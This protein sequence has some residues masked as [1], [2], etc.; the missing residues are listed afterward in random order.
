MTVFQYTAR[1]KETGRQITGT[2]DAEDRINAIK[3]LERMRLLPISVRCT[4]VTVSVKRSHLLYYVVSVV[5][6]FA[7]T[8]FCWFTMGKRPSS[9]N[10]DEKPEGPVA[11]S[12]PVSRASKV[13]SETSPVEKVPE[14]I[15]SSVASQVVQDDQ[16]Y[17]P[18]S[19]SSTEAHNERKLKGEVFVVTG[20]QSNIKLA[21]VNILAIPTVSLASHLEAQREEVNIQLA[22]VKF[23]LEPIDWAIES[24][25]D[26]G[27]KFQEKAQNSIRQIRQGRL[28]SENEMVSMKKESDRIKLIIEEKTVQRAPLAAKIVYLKSTAALLEGMPTPLE[29]ARTDSDGRFSMTLPRDVALTLVAHASRDVFSNTENYFWIVPLENDQTEMVLSNNNMSP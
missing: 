15:S 19:R 1:D 16:T 9:S 13:A 29:V 11:R 23:E 21:L 17:I 2:L 6:I 28:I 22:R 24:A 18:P 26:D 14:Q 3:Q 20:G 8:L 10:A 12:V 7:V 25:K 27:A 5:L 4:T